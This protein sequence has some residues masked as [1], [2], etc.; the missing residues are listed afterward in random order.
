MVSEVYSLFNF[1]LWKVS[2]AIYVRKSV[3]FCNLESER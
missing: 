1:F 3:G 2:G